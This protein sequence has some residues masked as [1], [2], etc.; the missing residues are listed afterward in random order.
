[1]AAEPT[2]SVIMLSRNNPEI[3]TSLRVTA[4]QLGKDDE[5]IVVDDH[6]SAKYLSHLER[7]SGE[8]GFALLHAQKRGNRS[9]NRNLGARFSKGDILVFSDGDMVML[10]T[11]ITYLKR[12]VPTRSASAFVGHMHGITYCQNGMSLVAGIDDVASLARTK[13]GR[14]QLIE[15]P[16]LADGRTIAKD[17]DRRYRHYYWL[18]FYSALCVVER[19]GFADV[20][21]FDESFVTWGSE[22]VDLGFRL[23]RRG[24]EIDFLEDLHSIH[25]PHRRNV[26]QAEASNW[27]NALRAVDR[28]RCWEWEVVATF[29]G[30]VRV[31][32]AVDAVIRRMRSLSLP[33]IHPAG[34]GENTL[35]IDSVSRTRPEGSVRYL[36]V[37]GRLREYHQLGLALPQLNHQ[38]I[39]RCYVSSNVF[40][41]PAVIAAEILREAT[42]LSGDVIIVDSGCR[43]RVDWG[44]VIKGAT[45]TYRGRNDHFYHDI[46]EFRFEPAAE[47][48]SVTHQR[49]DIR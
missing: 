27:E 49:L 38:E 8:L 14:R 12:A 22:D 3:E 32:A 18:N 9:H 21:G 28:Y 46:M 24:Y 23:Q 48:L 47:G 43:T 19:P 42:R 26:V 29:R 11:N 16:L 31:V 6:S 41:Y 20:G 10:D 45:F 35:V 44:A 7:L 1:M 36:D 13:E 34:E 37:T 5:L 33:D 4:Q 25:I 15:N 17:V 30:S 40:A 2:I 39:V